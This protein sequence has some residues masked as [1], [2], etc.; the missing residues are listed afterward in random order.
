MK[1]II[2]SQCN[3]TVSIT[4]PNTRNVKFCSVPCRSWYYKNYYKNNG[5]L[6]RQREYLDNRREA[7]GRPKIKREVCGKSFRQVGTH[8]IQRH[9]YTSAREYREDYGFDLKKGQLPKDYRELKAR[10]AIECGG[11]KNLV[12]GKKFWF[13]KGDKKAGR[14]VRSKETLERLHLGTKIL[15]IN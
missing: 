2:C 6:E 3:K 9:G 11:V 13:I 14:Y 5:G 8:V 10:K 1:T 4:N 12:I 7:D 15:I